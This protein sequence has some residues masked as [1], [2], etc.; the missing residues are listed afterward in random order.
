VDT[1]TIAIFF[2]LRTYDY[3]IGNHR[4]DDLILS[5]CVILSIIDWLWLG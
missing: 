4:K 1:E 3:L 2:S 5:K